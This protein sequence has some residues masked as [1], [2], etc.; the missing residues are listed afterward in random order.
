MS[1][2]LL[3][4][5]KSA[6]GDGLEKIISGYE[7]VYDGPVHEDTLFNK[8]RTVISYLEKVEKEMTY[9][10]ASGKCTRFPYFIFCYC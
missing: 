3:V 2:S 7:A 4:N 1:F 6:V 8:C 9:D 5:Q 10:R